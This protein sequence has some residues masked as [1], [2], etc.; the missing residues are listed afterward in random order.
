[1]ILLEQAIVI[2]DQ[3]LDD[4]S[5]SSAYELQLMKDRTQEFEY[6]WVFFY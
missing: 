6:G 2:G 1:M 4:M 3:Y 5:K